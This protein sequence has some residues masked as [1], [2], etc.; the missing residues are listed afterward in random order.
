MAVRFHHFKYTFWAIFRLILSIAFLLAQLASISGK[1]FK[2]EELPTAYITTG[3]P[4]ISQQLLGIYSNYFK[5]DLSFNYLKVIPQDLFQQNGNLIFLILHKNRI[6]SIDEDAFRDLDNLRVIYLNDNELVQIQSGLFRGN[7]KLRTIHLNNNR[8]EFIHPNAFQRQHNLIECDISNNRLTHFHFDMLQ[9]AKNLK[10][11][12]LA[13]NRLTEIPYDTIRNYFPNIQ[14]ISISY[15]SFNCAY[16]LGMVNEL[17]RN[18]LKILDYNR[19]EW[20]ADGMW[21]RLSIYGITCIDGNR[22]G[23]EVI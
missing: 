8:I 23:I 6:S 2:L 20:N 14:E 4:N 22:T 15:N 9:S 12:Y 19:L 5:M 16:A 11:L 1:M 21:K 10:K 3:E 18:R 7:S 13:E 17:S